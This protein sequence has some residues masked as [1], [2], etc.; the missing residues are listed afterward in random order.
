[1]FA[2]VLCQSL[3]SDKVV[4]SHTVSRLHTTSRSDTL[5]WALPYGAAQECS[6]SCVWHWQLLETTAHFTPQISPHFTTNF[7][8]SPTNPL[9]YITIHL[10]APV[11]AFSVLTRPQRWLF[12]YYLSRV[13]GLFT[14][15]AVHIQTVAFFQYPLT[16]CGDGRL[17]GV[18][19]RPGLPAR[20]NQHR[21]PAADLLFPKLPGE[22]FLCCTGSPVRGK[23]PRAVKY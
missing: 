22:D 14:V 13:G 2:Q 3:K 8:L 17:Q 6:M 23:R 11:S 9:S 19:H 21:P 16:R 7:N 18:C 1:M 10:F 15:F 12:F 4:P 5:T 20:H